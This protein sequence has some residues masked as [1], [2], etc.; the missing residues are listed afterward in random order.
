MSSADLKTKLPALYTRQ[1][2]GIAL[3]FIA[4]TFWGG[5]A[6]FAKFLFASHPKIDTLILSQTRSSFSFLL[7]ALYFAVVHRPVF[8]VAKRDLP[9]LAFVGIIGI[10][11]TNF[12]YYYTVKESTVATAILIQYTA[13]VLVM[14]YSVFIS[15]DEEM[16]VSKV[17]S[18][19]LAMLGCYL[20]VTGGAGAQIHIPPRAFLGGITSSL[21]FA[22]LLIASKRILRTYS[23]WTMLVYAFG[24][25]GLFWLFV[26]PPWSILAENYTA[27]DWGFLWLFAVVSILIPHSIFT[28][29]LT[30]LDAST[31]G[32][33]STMEPI[34]AIIIAYV[35][36]GET[37]TSIQVLGAATVVA[38]V[39]LLQIRNFP[40]RLARRAS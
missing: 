18:L 40:A 23:T 25:A 14:V 36:L 33:A 24:F 15:K 19:M 20:A 2:R 26:N 35:A 17:A 13:P 8:R 32:I 10:A 29:S 30:L 3:V 1:A 6:S 11:I 21:C 39:L 7:M 37:L 5:S 38:A 16:N 9:K 22:F 12:S 34:V 28:R 27:S 4:V 31:A